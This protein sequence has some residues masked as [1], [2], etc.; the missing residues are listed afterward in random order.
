MILDTI[1]IDRAFW[2]LFCPNFMR[3]MSMKW[4]MYILLEISI[5]NFDHKMDRFFMLSRGCTS[6]FL[7]INDYQV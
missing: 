5:L 3:G 1:L 2:N 4:I 6:W 7:I